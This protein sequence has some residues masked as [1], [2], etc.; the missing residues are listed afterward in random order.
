[1]NALPA[2]NV[3][4]AVALWGDLRDSFRLHLFTSAFNVSSKPQLQ[5]L[6]SPSLYGAMLNLII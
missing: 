3:N 6:F 2:L 5:S 1:M 4:H